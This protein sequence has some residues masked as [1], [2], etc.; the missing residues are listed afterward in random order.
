MHW[1]TSGAASIIALRC[2]H[3]SGRSDELWPAT[4]AP[5]PLRAAI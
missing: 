2:Q 4:T 5:A 1:T 3:A